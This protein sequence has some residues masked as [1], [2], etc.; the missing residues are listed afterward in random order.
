M[1][2]RKSVQLSAAAKLQRVMHQVLGTHQATPSGRS[3]FFRSLDAV[4]CDNRRGSTNRKRGPLETRH[5][6]N[7]GYDVF[8][9][10]M[11]GGSEENGLWDKNKRGSANSQWVALTR[12]QKGMFDS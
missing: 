3:G 11:V 4:R 1:T 5:N 2:H 12:E 8:R 6:H 9:R 7:R 10:E